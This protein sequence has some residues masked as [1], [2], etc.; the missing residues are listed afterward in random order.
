MGLSRV[1]G[2]DPITVMLGT[3][4]VDWPSD[5]TVIGASGNAPKDNLSPVGALPYFQQHGRTDEPEAR[6]TGTL[7]DGPRQISRSS[8]VSG[9]HS[10]ARRTTPRR[11]RPSGLAPS[12]S[13][14][15][16]SP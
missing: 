2:G 1:A 9:N 7:S 4:S 15:A 16:L 8:T 12:R 11:Q 3:S 14:L 10:L 13:I 6:A 5:L